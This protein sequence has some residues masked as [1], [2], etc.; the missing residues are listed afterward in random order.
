MSASTSV[1]GSSSS[2]TSSLAGSGLD[3]ETLAE[4][5]LEEAKLCSVNEGIKRTLTELLNC[6]AT[7]GEDNRQFRSWV[8]G[9]LME[10]ERELRRGRRRRS[11]GSVGSE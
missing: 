4:V 2:L 7:R 8:Q 10:A 6:E 1:F 5:A 11:A 9:R 3:D